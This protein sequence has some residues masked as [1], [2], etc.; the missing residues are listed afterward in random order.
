MPDRLAQR[1]ARWL[2]RPVAVLAWTSALLLAGVWAAAQVPLEWVPRIELPEVRLS[3]AWP[4]ASPRAVERYVTAPIERAVQRVPGTAAVESVSEEGQA[5]VILSVADGT[6]LGRYVA[7]VNEQLAGLRGVLPD[8]VVPRLTRQVPA[9]LRDAQGFMTIQLAGPASAGLRRLA[10]EGVAPRLRSLPGVAD[11][12]V[13][14]GAEEE[15]LVT[16]DADRLAAHDLDAA[17]VRQR[18]AEALTDAVYGRLRGDGRSLLLFHP[19]EADVAALRALPLDV[20]AGRVVRLADVGTAAL[21]PAP[22]RTLSRIDG[23][24]VVTLVVDRA[25]GSSLPGVAEAVR[26]RLEE[27]RAGLPDGTRLLVADDRS[28]AVRAQLRDLAWQGGAGLLL[29]VLVLTVLLRSLRACA[30]VLAGVA[31]ALAVALLLLVALGLSLNLLTL[32]GLVLVFG[33]LVDNAV[34]VVEQLMA[35]RPG[36][37]TAAE[38][39]AAALR[40]VGLPLVGGT[41]TTVA[42]LVPLVYLSGELRALFLPFGLLTALT[43]VASLVSAALLVPVLG[44]WLPAAPPPRPRG[45][46]RRWAAVPYR[47]VARY[48]R[49]TLLALALALGTPFWLL[50]DRLA[51]DEAAPRPARRLAALYDATLGAEAAREARKRWLDAALGG[52]LRPFFR[53]TQFGAGWDYTARPEVFVRLGFPSGNPIERADSLLQ[54]F[55]RIALASPAVARTLAH[56]AEQQATL[57]VQFAEAAFAGGAPYAVREALIQHAVG[58]GGIEVGVGGLL[59]EGYYSGSGMGVSGFTVRAYGPNYERLERLSHDFA[60]FLQARSRRVAGVDVNAGRYGAVPPREVLRLTWGAAEQGRTGLA[61]GALA[62]TLQPVLATRFPMARADLE[63]QAQVPV[64]LVVAGSDALDV[65]ALT[66]TP[67]HVGGTWVRLAG[68]AGYSVAAVPARVERANQQYRRYITVDYLGPY[69]MGDAFLDAALADFALP[70]GYRFERARFS[71][72]DEAAQEAFGW[73]LLGTVLLVFLITAAVF[74]SARLAFV[75]LL[76]VPLAALGVAAA[77]LTWPEVPF[78]EGAFIGAVLLAGIAVND[79]L[80]L[81]DSY[82]RHRVQ[83]PHTPAERLVRLAVRERLR[84]M[85][86]T[87]LTSV[88]ALAPLLLAPDAG[89]FWAGLAVTVVG[90]LLSAT[91]LA[92]PATVA[93]LC[94]PPFSLR[95]AWAGQ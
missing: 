89:D 67:W 38:R 3:A 87:T 47:A 52:F 86:T 16:L 81:V 9:A 19:A 30:V 50:P 84:P 33:L 32:A 11:V 35:Q 1:Y 31:A 53:H 59:P 95:S 12:V 21:Q 73:V 68:L 45:R 54:A 37:G 74:E 20:R 17:R 8:R 42:V 93:L 5:S 58:L 80:L 60:A 64:R 13:A 10:E 70:P 91:L 27:L 25:P 44:R 71:F 66:H 48:P 61:G 90:G 24:P 23:Q 46:L 28:E 63:G 41:L 94:L 56:V 92:P 7:E 55:E 6:D 57:R 82:R 65:E 51:L 88:A 26:A 49:L 15:L 69:T 39:A 85:W 4:G 62:A 34:V 79:S 18:L 22:L 14:G 76:S 29:V 83:R 72:F 36:A 40:A 2:A 77:F 78:A 75:V 43:L